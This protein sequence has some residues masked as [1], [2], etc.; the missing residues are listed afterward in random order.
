ML[1]LRELSYVTFKASSSASQ[2][3]LATVPPCFT[4]KWMY[5]VSRLTIGCDEKG[6]A[7][8]VVNDSGSQRVVMMQISP[9]DEEVKMSP[10]KQSATSPPDKSR[11]SACVSAS[12]RK[13]RT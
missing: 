2:D 1:S 10:A 13:K 12:N 11:C 4:R 5:F 3:D 6:G 9:P 7:C 8:G